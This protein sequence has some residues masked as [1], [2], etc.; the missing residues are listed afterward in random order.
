MIV[1]SDAII[2]KSMKYGETSRIVTLFTREFGRIGIIAKGARGKKARFGAALDIMSHSRIV[3][4]RK[5]TRDLQLLSQADLIEQFN[6]V[7]DDPSRLMLGFAMIE[8]LNA[9]VHGEE[10]HTELFDLLLHSLQQLGSIEKHPENALLL[11]L[12]HLADAFGVGLDL[13][14]CLRCRSNFGDESVLSGRALF[15]APDGGF[16]CSACAAGLRGMEVSG[17]TLLDLRWLKMTRG[18]AADVLE[19]SRT[20]VSQGIHVMHTHLKAHIPDMR[21]IRSLDLIDLFSN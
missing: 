19:V 8:F 6:R 11:Y 2:L 21:K 12:V 9:S 14:H 10:Q 20:S 13:E 4:Y 15:S 7:I 18:N 16:Y 17:E 3:F 1:S 5:D